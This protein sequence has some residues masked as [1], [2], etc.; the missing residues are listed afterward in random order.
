MHNTFIS[1]L[2]LHWNLGNGFFLQSGFSVYISTGTISGPL[3]NSNTGAPYFTFQ[4]HFVL[5][6]VKDGWNL[7]AYTYYEHNTKNMISGYTSGDIF[8]A[9]FTA[10]KQVGKGP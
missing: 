10:T 8:H 5:S 9:D 2:R 1:P 7:T 6:Y 3:G 4:P